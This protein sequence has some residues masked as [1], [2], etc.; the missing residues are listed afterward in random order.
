MR[1]LVCILALIL[2]LPAIVATTDAD[3]KIKPIPR[4]DEVIGK[5][6]A[7]ASRSTSVAPISR[8]VIHR[9]VVVG[10]KKAVVRRTRPATHAATRTVRAPVRTHRRVEGD[11]RESR[12]SRARARAQPAAGT[13][14]PRSAT[15]AASCR[16][17]SRP[18]RN[19]R[20]SA[21]SP[22]ASCCRPRTTRGRPGCL[23]ARDHG[24]L[25]G[26]SARAPRAGAQLRVDLHHRGG[27][28]S[29]ACSRLRRTPRKAR[30]GRRAPPIGSD[31]R[32]A[33]D[34][35]TR[36]DAHRRD[37]IRRPS[38]A[39]RVVSPPHGRPPALDGRARVRGC[40]RG[41]RPAAGP[42]LDPARDLLRLSRRRPAGRDRRRARIRSSRSRS[43][44]RT[45]GAVLRARP[46]A[47]GAKRRGRRGR[48]GRGR[49]RPRGSGSA[50]AQL[51]ARAQR[52]RGGLAGP[53]TTSRPQA[54]PPRSSGLSRD[55]PARLRPH[56]ARAELRPS[57]PPAARGCRSRR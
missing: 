37:R 24:G 40:E 49:R 34:G 6:A 38:R 10:T 31:H 45:V 25:R 15:E 12:P 36:V 55:R 35:C 42:R 32:A 43:R 28:R 48:R 56:R 7:A 11:S 17:S 9:N 27:F 13:C 30:D 8:P 44:H 14:R 46:A 39:H 53:S 54:Q 33:L 41:L 5:P 2:A 18:P 22:R 16:R 29:L 1:A 20:R 19:P 26:L 21:S 51:R 47:L 23:A 4:P 3:A 50:E 57:S 52:P